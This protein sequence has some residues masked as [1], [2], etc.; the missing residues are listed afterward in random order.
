MTLDDFTGLITE[1]SD[2]YERKQPKPHTIE[3]WYRLIKRIPHE[4]LKWIMRHIEDNYESF[5]KNITAALWEAY[6]EWQQA[7]PDKMAKESFFD[8]PD[9]SEG[10]IFARK[11]KNNISY[12]YVF[13]CV[14]CKQNHCRSYPESS[15]SELI[16]EGYDIL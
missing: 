12:K 5:P 2:F 7:N 3:L 14:K 11:T 1:L 16:A 6:T 15:K 10:L 8:C 13:R 9:C 4:P